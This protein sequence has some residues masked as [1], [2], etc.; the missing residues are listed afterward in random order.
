MKRLTDAVSATYGSARLADWLLDSLREAGYDLDRLT[1]DDL[2]TFDELHVMG[3]RATFE[4]GRLAGLT[5]SMRVLDIGCGLGGSART[6][7]TDSHA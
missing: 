1:M 2:I 7:V 4:L 3:R 5:D 6:L